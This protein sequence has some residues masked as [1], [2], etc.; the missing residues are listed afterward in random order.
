MSLT[1][2]SLV[3]DKQIA[4]IIRVYHKVYYVRY[5]ANFLLGIRGPK[6]LAID[7]KEEI[8]KFI[9][10]DLQLELKYS[11]LYHAKSSKVRYLGFDICIPNV[12]SIG[13]SKLKETIAFK[14]LRNRIK[15]KKKVIEDR[16]ESFLSRLIQKKIINKTN[17]ILAGVTNKIKANK[18]INNIITEEILDILKAP[19]KKTI[20]K[21]K[22]SNTNIKELTEKWVIEVKRYLKENW[23]KDEEL[24]DIIGGQELLEAHKHL[25]ECMSK[26]ISSKNLALM[27]DK[28]IKKFKNNKVKRYTINHSIQ[29]QKQSFYP[30][31]YLPQDNFVNRMREWGMIDK[32]INKPIANTY[33]FKYHDINIVNYYKSKAIGVLEYYKPA[34]NFHWLKK[35]VDY[36]MRYSLL[37]TLAR[38]H[39]KSV[40]EII[41]LM[42]KNTSIY[43]QTN[44]NELRKIASFLISSDIQGYKRGFTR[45]FDP[46][47]EFKKFK[48]PLVRMS[49]PKILYKECQV[50]G[51]NN[52]DIKIYHVKALSKKLYGIKALEYSFDRKQIPLCKVHHFD[53]Y[54][55][56]L[57]SMD[58]KNDSTSLKFL[59]KNK[60]EIKY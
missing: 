53:I 39:R 44:H 10:S 52:T 15:L 36:H 3:D 18:I 60:I 20:V 21:Q 9:K 17:I 43:V 6:S 12:K 41:G 31:I 22:D 24:I 57:A 16:W 56:R 29:S 28:N 2:Y 32:N 50:K 47:E 25:L 1:K 45:F 46:M 5:A 30:R 13:I 19:T 51:C 37:F 35:Q 40:S 8:S 23:L 49:I 11:D 42:G 54:A 38:K 33:V 27:V 26:A 7:T 14:K 48:T 34:I 4:D 58:I 55:G 59:N